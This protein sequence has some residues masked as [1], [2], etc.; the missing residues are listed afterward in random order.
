MGVLGHVRTC[1]LIALYQVFSLVSH[2]RPFTLSSNLMRFP[3]TRGQQ[4]SCYVGTPIDLFPTILSSAAAALA[5]SALPSLC[6]LSSPPPSAPC[7][8]QAK[9]HLSSNNS[10][11]PPFAFFREPQSVWSNCLS[12]FTCPW[13]SSWPLRVSTPLPF[14]SLKWLQTI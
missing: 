12:N 1:S 14:A 4:Y 13:I 7:F 11:D 8:L 9:Y 3:D 6:P 5:T 2:S 10:L